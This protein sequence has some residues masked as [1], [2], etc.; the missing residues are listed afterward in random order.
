MQNLLFGPARMSDSGRLTNTITAPQRVQGYSA[1]IPVQLG[2]FNDYYTPYSSVRDLERMDRA[3]LSGHL[4]SRSGLRSFFTGYISGGALVG[5]YNGSHATE[6]AGCYECYLRKASPTTVAVVD[7][8]GTING[9]GADDAL[10]PDDGTIAIMVQNDDSGPAPT[11]VLFGLAANL[12][13]HKQGSA[14]S[15]GSAGRGTGIAA[16]L[17]RARY[18]GYFYAERHGHVIVSKGFGMA[19]AEDKIPNMLQTK[20]PAFAVSRFL[21]G[22]AI[23]RLQDEG[24]LSVQDRMCKYLAACPTAWRSMT[25]K[26]LITN[27]SGMPAY[28]ALEGP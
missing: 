16:Y 5:R 9:F 18:N 14:P 1:G 4:L 17:T 20:W 15:P 7:N 3:L 23:M 27:T 8:P 6:L 13:W 10:S 28:F 21:Q 19:D 26:E 12:L 25:I 22:V 24:K 2:N 11:D